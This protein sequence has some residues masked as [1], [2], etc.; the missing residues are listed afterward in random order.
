MTQ[1]LDYQL[2]FVARRF[3]SQAASTQ[4]GDAGLTENFGNA[5]LKARKF[6]PQESFEVSKQQEGAGSGATC[7]DSTSIKRLFHQF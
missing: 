6:Y 5:W 7:S 3:V 2:S 4:S 1:W